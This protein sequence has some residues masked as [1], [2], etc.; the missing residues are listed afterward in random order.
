MTTVI[1]VNIFCNFI[2]TLNP[3]TPPKTVSDTAIT[4][5][6]I[7]ARF[8]STPPILEKTVPVARVARETKTVSHP[9]KIKYERNPGTM[10]PL[11]PKEA[12]ANTI[13]GAFE[14]LPAKELIPTKKKEQMVPIIAAHVACLNEIPNPKKK[15]P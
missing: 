9:T 12:R 10:L 15:E 2:I 7:K 1:T 4:N 13:V 6:R 8:W 5:P 3:R 14:R 11:T